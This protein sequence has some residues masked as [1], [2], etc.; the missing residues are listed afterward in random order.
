MP[1]STMAG[2]SQWTINY[3]TDSLLPDCSNY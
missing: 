1:L 2:I 3:P